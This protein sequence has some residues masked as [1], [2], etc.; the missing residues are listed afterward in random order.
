[1]KFIVPVCY[2]KTTVLLIDDDSIQNDLLKP[3]IEKHNLCKVFKNGLEAL[4]FLDHYKP[5]PIVNYYMSVDDEHPEQIKF[6]IPQVQKKQLDHHKTSEVAVA[7]VDYQMPNMNGIEV[8]KAIRQKFP[9]IK[10]IMLTGKADDT[11][12]IEAHN[13]KHIDLFLRKDFNNGLDSLLT[14][15]DETLLDYFREQSSV[16][17]ISLLNNQEGYP[18]YLNDPAFGAFF[19]N[20]VKVKNIKEFYMINSLGDYLMLDEQGHKVYLMTRTEK[21]LHFFYEIAHFSDNNDIAVQIKERECAPFFGDIPLTE[22]QTEEWKKALQP[23][24]VIPGTQSYY[25]AIIESE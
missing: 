9:M 21:Q 11:V 23:L 25:Y 14:V 13:H 5:S 17:N 1:M 24:E 15:L 22:I 18:Q 3:Q 7:I 20:L 4:S 6:K 2:Y 12:A 10:L 8:C 16:L 19:F